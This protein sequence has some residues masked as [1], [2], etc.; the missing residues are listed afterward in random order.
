MSEI[1]R[2][3]LNGFMF[4]P[5]VRFFG[6]AS[7]ICFIGNFRSSGSGKYSERWIENL[8]YILCKCF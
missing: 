5:R 8:F 3:K 4:L 6:C 7:V 2:D 1:M